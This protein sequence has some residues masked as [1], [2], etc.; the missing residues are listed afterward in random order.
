MRSKP[1]VL[2][3]GY[4]YL[5]SFLFLL[6]L[7]PLA[8]GSAAQNTPLFEVATKKSMQS[9]NIE[10]TYLT[11]HKNVLQQLYSDDA[12]QLILTIPL[13]G[14]TPVQVTLQKTKVLGDHFYLTTRSDS[15]RQGHPYK[16]GHYYQNTM[17]GQLAAISIFEDAINGVVVIDGQPYSLGPLASEEKNADPLYVFYNEASAAIPDLICSTPPP[18]PN[19]TL[20]GFAKA[21]AEMVDRLVYNYLEVDYELYLNKGGVTETADFITGLFNVIQAIYNL[22]EVDLQ[23]SE[24]SIWT[25]QDTYD[26]SSTSILLSD[27][28]SGIE[29]INGDL[30]HYIDFGFIGGRA[31][32]DGLCGP[33][34]FAVSSVQSSFN[35]FPLY[36]YN[37][38]L[39]A[40][41]IGHNLGSPH[42]HNC[43]WPGG[44]IDNCATPEGS[45]DPGPPPTNGG[46]IM[47]YCTPNI[48][49]TLGLGDLPGDLI[50]NTI[51]SKTCLGQ[52]TYVSIFGDDIV[53]CP[54]QTTTLDATYPPCQNCTY[55]WNDGFVGPIRVVDVYDHID[56][57]VEVIDQQGQIFADHIAVNPYP[58]LVDIDITYPTNCD[59]SIVTLSPSGG[60]GNY[61]YQWPDGSSGSSNNNLPAGDYTITISDGVCDLTRTISLATLPGIQLS[62][63][64]GASFTD[65]VGGIVLTPS[66]NIVLGGVTN[67][68]DGELQSF[69]GSS[70]FCLSE[71][72]PDG[73]LN[74]VNHFGGSNYDY[75][76]DVIPTSDDGY[77]LA[78]ETRS[79]D[80]D[81]N[82]Q[83]GNGDG[84]I[85]KTNATGDI[86]WSQN[87]G[88]TQYDVFNAAAPS[89]DGNYLLAGNTLSDD[90]DISNPLGLTD[91]WLVKASANGNLLWSKNFGGTSSD[92]F[93]DVTQA[94]DG[95]IWAVGR[96]FSSDVD[97][98]FN[99]G[100]TDLFVVRLNSNGDKIWSN[101]YGGQFLDEGNAIIE[102]ADGNMV[103]ANV[104]SSN[105][106]DILDGQGVN[107]AWI[108]KMDPNGNILWSKNFGG[109]SSEGAEAITETNDGGLFIAGYSYNYP[110]VNFQSAEYFVIKTDSDGNLEWENTYGGD[111]A[112]FATA[113]LQ[114]DNDD[115]YIGGYANDDGADVPTNEGHD[116]WWLLHLS[117]NAPSNVNIEASAPDVSNGPV[118]LT[119]VPMV[120]NPVWSTGE[121]TQSI[122]VNT[123]GTYTLTG[124]TG[125]C[126]ASDQVIIFDDLCTIEYQVSGTDIILTFLTASTDNVKLFDADYAVV[127]NCDPWNGTPCSQTETITGLTPGA[128]YHLSL[129]SDNCDESHT[130]VID[131][132]GCDE[133][134]DNDGVCADTDCDDNDPAIPT[135]PGTACDDGDP[136]TENDVI[137]SDGCTCLGTPISGECNIVVTT[138][139]GSIIVSGLTANENTKLFDPAFTIV[140]QCSPWGGNP[141]SGLEQITGLTEGDTYFLSVESDVCDEWIPVVVEGGGCPDADNDGVCEGEDCDD[142]DPAIPTDPGTAC[143]DGDPDTENDVI[144]SD[145]CTCLGTPISGECNIVVTTANGSITVSGLT[146]N[147]NTKLFN[148]SFSIVWECNPWG[149]NPCSG[150]EQITGLTEGDTYFLSVQSDVCDEWIPVTVQGGGCT[151]NDNDGVCEGED[152]DDNDP[153]VPTAPGTACDDGD[154]N[155]ENDIIQSDGCTCEGTPINTDLADL[156][157]SNFVYVGATN[158]DPGEVLSF[159]FSA[160]NIG[161]VATGSF[162]IKSYISVD[163]TLSADDVQDGVIPTGNFGPG[164]TVDNI[165]GALTVPAGMAAGDYYVL[166]FIDA[167]DDI[168]ELSES[169]NVMASS[170]AFTVNEGV[171]CSGSLSGTTYLGELDDHEYFISNNIAT[172]SNAQA[173]AAAAG[174][175]LVSFGDAAENIFVRDLINEISFIGYNDDDDDGTFTWDSGEPVSYTNIDNP[176]DDR[177][178]H[179]NFWDGDWGFDGPVTQRKFIIERPCSAGAGAVAVHSSSGGGDPEANASELEIVRLY[180]NPVSDQLVVQ[181]ESGVELAVDLV[182]YDAY[183]GVL[184][185]RSVQLVKGR[186]N[187]VVTAGHLPKGVFV[188]GLVN[189][190][191]RLLDV[192]RFVKG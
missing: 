46:T 124:G 128:T 138:A 122:V 69:L 66:G 129:S 47:S 7:L 2:G 97:A 183:G 143:D 23:I 39:L 57:C 18:P 119:A 77:L 20:P 115:Y 73:T 94:S 6:L 62:R 192:G 4:S 159:S 54:N 19:K 3:Q 28:R 154:P 88:G 163:Q 98:P 100:S 71:I 30:A 82:S 36:S 95:S 109:T 8:V 45:C 101:T 151:D 61:T 96:S 58:L 187:I 83:Y 191:G 126:M 17:P 146:A 14:K 41:E 44:A 51:D 185:L 179:M 113:V 81:V 26:D 53:G 5:L 150:L 65:R 170:P 13:S 105:D 21:A 140:W 9:A 110:I 33:F 48:D 52:K 142:N 155:T 118:T 68:L 1:T 182:V 169:N 176:I 25:Q 121:T 56:Y 137:Q 35:D 136:N 40:H 116:D 111:D 104:S 114:A 43:S 161:T 112:D 188:I 168:E 67:G 153:S 60:D 134:N 80:G 133:D 93:N 91:A 167:D 106:G 162:T 166:L 164:Q 37:G 63:A 11:L 160:S 145:G 87:F 85:V 165:G 148:P 141:C 15:G 181:V 86:E 117:E 180:P 184:E 64:M 84:W 171:N 32:I 12:D 76:T 177:Y 42:T 72:A 31:Y 178:G 157:L 123:P 147:E 50:R 22:E 78:G 175:Y 132:G 127:W 130:I 186:K 120:T 55:V 131:D 79:A 49:F 70:D 125:S 99:R 156:V 10:G 190:S 24:I 38:Y 152:C 102:T 103:I 59:A 75:C 27:F 90:M 135:D 89:N 144:Q 173:F 74:W 29:C 172:W 16:P 92:Y 139:N 108:I 189:A 174:G 149:G 34:A 158:V 107:D